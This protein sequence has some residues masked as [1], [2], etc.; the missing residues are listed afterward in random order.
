MFVFE[1]EIE[2]T[3]DGIQGCFQFVR[4]TVDHSLL[5]NEYLFLKKVVLWLVVIGLIMG[6]RVLSH[7]G[8]AGL[9][10]GLVGN[11]VLEGILVR[12]IGVLG[13]HLSAGQGL[14]GLLVIDHRETH[15]V[16]LKL[17][18]NPHF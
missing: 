15:L 1:E 10:V 16:L 7:Y 11:L 8:L 9:L 4:E 2:H 12:I 18:R 5:E 13:L 3:D 6:P 17:Q 14:Q